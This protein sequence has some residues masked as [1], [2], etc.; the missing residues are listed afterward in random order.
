EFGSLFKQ[1][2]VSHAGLSFD[3]ATA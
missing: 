2:C 1:L 3:V